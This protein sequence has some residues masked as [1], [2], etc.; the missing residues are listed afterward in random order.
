MLRVPQKLFTLKLSL[1]NPC[2]HCGRTE[3]RTGA[4]RKPQEASLHCRACKRF[5]RWISAGELKS[6]TE[7]GERDA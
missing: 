1:N 5:I 4:G 3:T 7:G 2:P 6:L